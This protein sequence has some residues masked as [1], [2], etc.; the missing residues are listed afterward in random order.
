MARDNGSTKS[1]RRRQGFHDFPIFKNQGTYSYL[2]D[3]EVKKADI[4]IG[5]RISMVSSVGK[6]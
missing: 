3:V 4:T 2:E 5:Q 1:R 6:E